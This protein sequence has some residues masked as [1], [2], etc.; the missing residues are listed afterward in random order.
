MPRCVLVIVG[1][2]TELAEFSPEK[3][4]AM[5]DGDEELARKLSHWADETK[6]LTTQSLTKARAIREETE[7]A[8][9]EA[10]KAAA[11]LPSPSTPRKYAYVPKS[12]GRNFDDDSPRQAYVFKT[13]KS[14]NLAS[15]GAAS[16]ENLSD[17]PTP[18]PADASPAKSPGKSPVKAPAKTPTTPETTPV[19]PPAAPPR[20]LS[21]T[22]S[23]QEP[24]SG[25]SS[26][27]SPGG[28]QRRP[29]MSGAGKTPE[30][31]KIEKARKEKADREAKSKAEAE[32]ATARALKQQEK[33]N[34]A[35]RVAK[36]ALQ[37][38]AAAEQK[39]QLL[40]QRDAE[41]ASEKTAKAAEEA[42]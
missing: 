28:L 1:Q 29:S 4:L 42:K 23:G 36:T 27:A 39:A 38:A 32:A 22:G 20:R 18:P 40:K 7:K 15:P 13:K 17:A 2:K 14:S 12:S 5:V 37:A 24:L 10:K 30:Q 9:K 16:E 31:R 3:M 19:T 6:I 8:S 21:R 25:A 33:D 34:E 26:G 41:K 11:A 35:A